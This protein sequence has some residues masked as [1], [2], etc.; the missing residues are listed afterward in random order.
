MLNSVTTWN[1]G[2]GFYF[3]FLN[4]NTL[5]WIFQIEWPEDKRRIKMDLLTGT[6][7]FSSFSL[8]Q[9]EYGLTFTG[10]CEDIILH[11]VLQ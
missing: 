10:L 4:T 2:H 9:T 11:S 6:L 8:L 1:T 3:I 5:L 7:D